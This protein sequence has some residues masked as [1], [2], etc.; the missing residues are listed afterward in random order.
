MQV[1]EHDPE[2]LEELD[3]SH[4][5]FRVDDYKECQV[6]CPVCGV[7]YAAPVRVEVDPWMGQVMAVVASGQFGFRPSKGIETRGVNIRLMFEG[8]C[9]HSWEV[10]IAFHKGMTYVTS[11]TWD[12]SERLGVIWRD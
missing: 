11:T 8:E 1:A 7:D 12:T 4:P 10:V 3:Q 5:V 2:P 6:V 9:D